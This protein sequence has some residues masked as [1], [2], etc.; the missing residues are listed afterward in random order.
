M[1]RKVSLILSGALHTIS[2]ES[3]KILI[4]CNC[5]KVISDW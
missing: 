1:K 5:R 4:L 3:N 2:T